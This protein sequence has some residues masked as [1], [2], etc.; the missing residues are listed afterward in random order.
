MGGRSFKS[1]GYHI[2]DNPLKQGFCLD[3]VKSP[4]RVIFGVGDCN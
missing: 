4:E 1:R 2:G 3:P